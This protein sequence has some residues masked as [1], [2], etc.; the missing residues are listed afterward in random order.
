MSFDDGELG[1]HSCFSMSTRDHEQR[2]SG[3]SAAPPAPAIVSRVARLSTLQ[4]LRRPVSFLS[5]SLHKT[6]L[7][8]ILVSN[9]FS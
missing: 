4:R 7:A 2:A 3:G 6:Y 9:I 5:R 1:L 8:E